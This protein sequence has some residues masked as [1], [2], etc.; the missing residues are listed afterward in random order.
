MQRQ[1]S[2][3]A[4]WLATSICS[5]APSHE[6]WTYAEPQK[7]T[8]S[9]RNAKPVEFPPHSS[10][11]VRN[12]LHPS[13]QKP[14]QVLVAKPPE[15]VLVGSTF[16]VVRSNP[17]WNRGQQ[18][19]AEVPTGTVKVLTVR[20]NYILA[21]VISDGSPLSQHLFPHYPGIMVGDQLR[22]QRQRINRKKILSPTST[23]SYFDLFVDPSPY[24]STFELSDRG[25]LVLHRVA[26]KYATLRLPLMLIE[27]HTDEDGPQDVNQIESYQRALTVRQFLIA[28]MG[29][30]AERLVAL[31]LGE[32]Q[33]IPEPHLPESRR[34]ARR[35]VIKVKSAP[36]QQ[37]ALR[38]KALQ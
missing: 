15:P 36:M 17:H 38:P 21:E 31:G 6:P 25:K 35:I 32:T 20:S 11:T 5:A 4:C 3:L 28:T 1:I 19:Q 23:I 16:Q 13:T 22:P 2:L 24:P 9:I 8:A 14:T 29:F 34:E 30:D 27:G 7:K 33:P 26:R 12:V 10:W 37:A 18:K